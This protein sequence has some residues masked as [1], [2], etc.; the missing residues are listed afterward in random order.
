M[1]SLAFAFRERRKAGAI[2]TLQTK[3]K[4]KTHRDTKTWGGNMYGLLVIN[5][6]QQLENEEHSSREGMTQDGT[7]WRRQRETQRHKAH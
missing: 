1:L 4:K 2:V 3:K 7:D 6:H 5:P